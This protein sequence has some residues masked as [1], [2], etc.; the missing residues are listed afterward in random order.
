MLASR[1]LSILMTLQARGRVSA[2]DLA[3]EF[4]VSVRTI[5]RDIDELSAAGVPVYAEKGRNGGF[6]LLDGYRTRLTGLDRPEAE[7]LFLA[8]LPGAAAQ[9]G[10]GEALARA[11]LKLLT[12]LPEI[13]RDDAER[14]GRRFHLDPV[15]WF[16][17]PDEQA[18]LPELAL[19]VWGGRKLKLRYDSWKAV[20]EREVAPLGIVL[21]AGLWYLVAAVDGRP[22]T[23]RVASILS[24]EVGDV[25]PPPP[26]GFDLA[27]Y[28]AGFCREYETRM[29]GLTARVR[30][31]PEA[32]RVLARASRA[33]A[34]AVEAAGAPDARGWKEATIPIE[35]E[36]QAVWELLRLGPRLEVLE[37]VAVRDRLKTALA[38]TAALYN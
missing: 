13:A 38:E 1:L 30:A 24:L 2:R 17:A 33:A 31:S 21:K 26:S 15:G 36:A 25:G 37:P 22:R 19:A 18:I 7:A 10:V 6:A 29:Q 32:L 11:R 12:A 35:S 3:Q 4:E 5:Y 14:V 9:L 16:Q 34:V 28:W 23:Y 8:G 27:A 20:V